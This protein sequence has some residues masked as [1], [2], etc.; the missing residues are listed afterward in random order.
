MI[1]L[2]IDSDAD[3]EHS[4]NHQLNFFNL[5]STKMDSGIIILAEN[6]FAFDRI[7]DQLSRYLTKSRRQKVILMVTNTN[8]AEFDGQANDILPKF[9]ERIRI[10]NIILIAPCSNGPKV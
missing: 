2:V 6:I 5:T 8:E 4:M 10:I 7:L 9:W 3:A 1:S